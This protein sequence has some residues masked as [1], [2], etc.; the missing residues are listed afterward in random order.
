MKIAIVQRYK[1][2]RE[3]VGEY[4][5]TR[6][7]MEM[8]GNNGIGLFVITGPEDIKKALETCDGLYVPGGVDVDPKFYHEEMNGTLEHYDWM[9]ELDMAA[10]DAFHKAGR[11]ILGICRG[12]QIINVFFGGTLHQDIKGHS[13]ER[14]YVKVKE[15]SFIDE[16]YH[17]ERLEVNSWHHQA[18][19]DVAEGF[20]VMAVSDDGIIEALNCGNIYTVQ[21]HPEMYDPDRFIRWFKDN[22]FNENKIS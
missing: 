22:V 15:G 6:D 1:L 14:H 12:Q 4:Y 5:N 16:I 2:N 17:T 10:I 11:P 20:E 9:D 7:N 3:G 21:W 18:V 19:K 8:F 13:G